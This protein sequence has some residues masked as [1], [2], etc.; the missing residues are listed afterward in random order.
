LEITAKKFAIPNEKVLFLKAYPDFQK[1]VE[2][3]S[4]QYKKWY[5]KPDLNFSKY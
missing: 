5:E 3:G 1:W 2:T 4:G